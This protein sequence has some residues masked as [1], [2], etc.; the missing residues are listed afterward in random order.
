MALWR[1]PEV[2]GED[3]MT[4]G[5]LR[6]ELRARRLV[7]ERARARLA[8][9]PDDVWGWNWLTWAYKGLSGLEYELEQDEIAT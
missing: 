2:V 5:E 3:P 4:A 9:D 6:L 1:H 8:A 7:I